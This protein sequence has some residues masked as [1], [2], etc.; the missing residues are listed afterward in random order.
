MPMLNLPLIIMGGSLTICPRVG[1][2]GRL[3]YWWR[4]L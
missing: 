3:Y 1:W 4:D 2:L